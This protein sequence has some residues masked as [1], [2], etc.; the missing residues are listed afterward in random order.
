MGSMIQQAIDLIQKHVSHEKKILIGDR[1]VDA[2]SDAAFKVENP[3]NGENFCKVL[4]GDVKEI[5]SV[6]AAATVSLDSEVWRRM[7]AQRG[8]APSG[9]SPS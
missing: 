8:A 4:A 9:E 6:G 2:V 5:D 7:L 3:A 1:S